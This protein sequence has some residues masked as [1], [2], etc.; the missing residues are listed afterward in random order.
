MPGWFL[1]NSDWSVGLLKVII[2]PTLEP[3]LMLLFCKDWASKQS[4]TKA[5]AVNKLLL[6]V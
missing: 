3:I 1:S 2:L 5:I 6:G 4:L